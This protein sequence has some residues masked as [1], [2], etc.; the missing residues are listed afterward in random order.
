[1]GRRV[2]GLLPFLNP[3][4]WRTGRSEIHDGH[5]DRRVYPV[6]ARF[7]VD[8]P[9]FA[10][11]ISLVIMLAGDGRR[12]HPARGALPGRDAGHRASL[13]HLPRRQRH[14]RARH[15]RRTHRGAGQR[16]RRDDV[17]VVPLHQR[18]HLHAQRHLQARHRL[19]HGAG[20]GP[21]PRV[22]GPAGHPRAGAERGHH[23]QED[24]AQHAD[25]REPGLPGKT[26]RRQV[27]SATTRPSTSAT[28][29]ADSPASPASRISASATT[30]SA[31]GSIRTSWP[32]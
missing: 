26:I 18:R 23:G 29:W 9:I 24:V 7:F 13:R 19:G 31:P 4:A 1:M 15:G 8:R 32:R 27:S 10:T 21:E 2:R 25:D 14:H 16:R 5:S 6:I 3:H 11:V 12:L 28:N 30:A 17:H 20:A 22:A